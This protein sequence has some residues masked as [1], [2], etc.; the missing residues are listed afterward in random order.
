MWEIMVSDNG[1]GIES[2]LKERL[3]DMF[4]TVPGGSLEDSGVDL[5]IAR[6]L[7]TRE[8]G[9]IWVESV[10]GEGSTF[11]LTLPKVDPPLNAGSEGWNS[12]VSL[13]PRL[14]GPDSTGEGEGEGAR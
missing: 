7:V 13:D 14:T 6:K 8:G 3:F 10:P 2:A 9:R 5:G 11:F 1:P 4:F 12:S